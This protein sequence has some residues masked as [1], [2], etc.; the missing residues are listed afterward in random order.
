[1]VCIASFATMAHLLGTPNACIF[2]HNI[3]LTYPLLNTLNLNESPKVAARN[4]QPEISQNLLGKMF[5]QRFLALISRA[6]RD[7][8]LY[9]S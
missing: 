9:Y 2:T 1:M 6:L 8:V 7:K 4:P 5:V 3:F